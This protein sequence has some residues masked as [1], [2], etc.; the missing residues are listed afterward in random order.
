MS[1]TVSGSGNGG[2]RSQWACIQWFR[3]RDPI[4]CGRVMSMTSQSC[5]LSR[6]SGSFFGHRTPL[7][8]L[9]SRSLGS[10]CDR[11]CGIS[12]ARTR[13][14]RR[15]RRGSSGS[16]CSAVSRFTSTGGST[17]NRRGSQRSCRSCAVYLLRGTDLASAILERYNA[18]RPIAAVLGS[19]TVSGVDILIASVN[20]SSSVGSLS[21]I[22]LTG[23]RIPA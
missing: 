16:P 5:R 13:L 8:T 20:A 19:G 4:F 22:I 18:R 21:I 6:T 2:T 1:I 15:N 9:S 17:G 3:V 7:D 11:R 23:T 10:R 12:T 14:S